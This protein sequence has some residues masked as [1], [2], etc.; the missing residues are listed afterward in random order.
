MIGNINGIIGCVSTVAAGTWNNT[1]T[2]AGVTYPPTASSACI[3]HAVQITG[4][5][6]NAVSAVTINAGG[7]LDIDV[8]RS[9]IFD[10]AR[11]NFN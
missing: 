6:T 5:N 3:G 9:L 8:T 2:W 7:S 10:R 11:R 1:A 4:G